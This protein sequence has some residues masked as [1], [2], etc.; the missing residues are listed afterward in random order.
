[1]SGISGQPGTK[2]TEVNSPIPGASE[3]MSLDSFAAQAKGAGKAG[4]SL[5]SFAA[6][7]GQA[8][9]AP[10][11][12]NDSGY[13]G[14]GAGLLQATA[15]V[16]PTAL[17]IAGGIVGSVAG[18]GGMAAMGM[19]GAAA[20]M[21]YRQFIEQEILGKP[22]KDP[23]KLW[24]EVTDSAGQTGA[25]LLAG[26]GALKV[27]G[28]AG[29]L[30]LESKVGAAL[31]DKIAATTAPAVKYFSDFTHNLKAGIIAPVTDYLENNMARGTAEQSGDQIKGQLT[32][33]IGDKFN[34]FKQSYAQLNQA[35]GD[36]PMADADK[37]A[38]TGKLR[39]D[40]RGFQGNIYNSVKQ[41]ATRIDDAASPQEIHS[42]LS[43]VDAEIQRLS[44]YQTSG[45]VRDKIAALQ[46]FSDR[47]GDFMENF[48]NGIAQ[49]V[50]KGKASMEEMAA[51]EKM[52]GAQA[53]P[54]V[55]VD[56]Q[57]LRQ[58]A[59]GVAKDFSDDY[60]AKRA[61]VDADY[62]K[63]RG[64]LEDVGDQTRINAG[65]QGPTQFMR[66]IQDVPSEQLVDRMFLPKNAAALR[67]MQA[68]TPDVFEAVKQ[69]RIRNI[70]NDSMTDGQVN[71]RKLADNFQALP[72]SA[73]SL[74]ISGPQL[75][76]IQAIANSANLKV[77]DRLSNNAVTGLV[78]NVIDLTH[79]STMAGAKIIR[80]T[81]PAGAT[82]VK[83]GIGAEGGK[84][85]QGLSST[86]Y[87][88]PGQQ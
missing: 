9:S 33:I 84:A 39:A 38:L 36:I 86:Y 54:T 2:P 56:P 75:Q 1:M 20:G 12:G 27:A 41:Y 24:H 51:F 28:K 61:A 64:F 16:A 79:V 76:Q 22:L 47:A 74:I 15:D 62:S 50:A 26:E 57:N 53:N 7:A 82:A 17:G 44:G 5:D 80:D 8:P 70:Y 66:S 40:A 67:E 35:V 29:K 19:A 11:G 58:Y 18:P 34:S 10:T 31:T 65:K 46:Q 43:D 78:R 3:G 32:Q 73:R 49:R 13:Q 81:S 77:I 42:V 83:Q 63:F 60:I 37:L 87:P 23:D 55:P 71:L 69:A 45:T 21:G 6:Q 85:L 30:A 25:E 59:K 4:Q 52:A 68:S 48:T 72:E 14:P 88:Q